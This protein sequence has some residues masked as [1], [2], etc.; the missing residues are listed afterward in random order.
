MLVQQHT[1]FDTT[2]NKS[3]KIMQKEFFGTLCKLFQK[4]QFQYIFYFEHE[5]AKLQNNKKNK[6]QLLDIYEN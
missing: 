1:R 3:T 4:K 2:P 6:W 5:V